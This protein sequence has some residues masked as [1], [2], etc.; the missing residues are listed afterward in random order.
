MIIEFL[1]ALLIVRIESCPLVIMR[2]DGDDK[3]DGQS[4]PRAP[5]GIPMRKPLTDH[6][7]SRQHQGTPSSHA[8]C[9]GPDSCAAL[10]R[11]GRSGLPAPARTGQPTHLSRYRINEADLELDRIHQATTGHGPKTGHHEDLP[12]LTGPPASQPP[13]WSAVGRAAMSTGPPTSLGR[14]I[15]GQ[16]T[17]HRAGRVVQAASDVHKGHYGVRPR[18]ASC[19]RADRLRSLLRVR[20]VGQDSVRSGSRTAGAQPD[21]RL[22]SGPDELRA[23]TALPRVSTMP[24]GF[25]LARTPGALRGQ[26]ATGGVRA[27]DQQVRD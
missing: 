27:R 22:A 4:D 3:H 15:P 24:R 26:P 13:G 1:Y 10:G 17:H 21:R 20:L 9:P 19:V 7:S 16:D 8:Q 5:S 25:G 23:V 6:R 14:R 2:G 12:S 11:T 18:K